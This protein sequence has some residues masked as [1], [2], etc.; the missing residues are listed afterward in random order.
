MSAAPVRLAAACPMS[1]QNIEIAH[2]EW[3]MMAE[4]KPADSKKRAKLR[5]KRSF[6]TAAKSGK[7]TPVFSP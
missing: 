2:R 1:A 3:E 4:M 6:I 5:S 7:S